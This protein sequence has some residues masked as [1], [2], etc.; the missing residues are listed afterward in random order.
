MKLHEYQAKDILRKRGVYTLESQ[1]CFTLEEAKQ[2]IKE[3]GVPCAVKA[4]VHAGGRGKVG[5]V[6]LAKNEQEAAQYA[7][8]ILAMT[9]KT[10]QTTG[11]GQKVSCVLI[12]KGTSIKKELYVSMLVDRASSQMCI[13]ASKEGGMDIEEVAQKNPESIK[14]V[15]IDKSIGLM[16]F[17]IRLLS[18]ELEL[19]KAVQKKF[20]AMLMGMY[21]T[22]LDCDAS[23]IEINPLIITDQDRVVALDAKMTIDDN[24]L[25][26][27]RALS[28][29]RDPSQEDAKEI[30]AQHHG[31][32][33][34]ALEGSIGCMVNGAGLA[35]AT[36]DIIK[37]V[38]GQP[39]NF[40]DV[41]GSA[42]KERVE[43]A[44]RIIVRDPQV[45]AIFVNVF[46]GIAQCDVIAEGVVK[47]ASSLELKLPLIVRLQGT[48]VDAGREILNKSGL[49][50]IAANDMLEG[51]KLAVAQVK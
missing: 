6:K 4:Q 23:M 8:E 48:N 11:L 35:M 31:L 34:V 15:Y 28:E 43:E 40:L 14:R 18:R 9:I 33:Y 41:G 49:S 32:S 26:R 38:G 22:F 5:G 21:R 39:A 45:K 17:Q 7:E 1:V 24:A 30:E 46:G 51:A 10:A 12:E 3:I 47:A 19:D 27:Q 13:L 42:T 25:F 29:M 36:M 37:H 2:A 16:P 50:I 44:L 20:V